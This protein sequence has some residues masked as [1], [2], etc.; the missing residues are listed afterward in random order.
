MLGDLER[1]DYRRLRSFL[2][3]ACE[4]SL[5]KVAERLASCHVR[6]PCLR[7]AVLALAPTRPDGIFRARAEECGPRC[8]AVQV[9]LHLAF[10]K[11]GAAILLAAN[12]PKVR[13]EFLRPIP[14]HFQAD[15]TAPFMTAA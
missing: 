9:H 5:P 10:P 14:L 6:S 12:D 3:V 1:L 8:V 13:A 4:A 2:T 15:E 11:P 7:P